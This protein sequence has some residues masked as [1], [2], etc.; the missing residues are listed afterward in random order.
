MPATTRKTALILSGGGARGA[1]QVGVLKAVGEILQ[2]KKMDN[3]F[4]I[5]SGVSAG[6]INTVSLACSKDDF[7]TSINKMIYLWSRIKPSQVFNVQLLSVGKLTQIF[8]SQNSFNAILST[9]P[10]KETLNKY[11]DFKQIDKNI[12][13][14]K[15]ET[16]IL[17]ANN[18]NTNCAVSFYDTNAKLNKNQTHWPDSRRRPQETDLRVEHVLAS[19][20]IPLLFPP[21]E[22]DGFK[23]GDGCVRNNTPCSPSLRMGAEKLFVVGVRTQKVIEKSKAQTKLKAAED[24]TLNDDHNVTM[25]K[26]INTLLNAIMLDSVEQDVHRILKIN[27]LVKKAEL[28]NEDLPTGL[29]EIPALCISPSQGLGELAREYA[30]KLPRLLRT[31]LNMFGSLDDANEILSYLMFDGDYCTKLIEIGYQ[32]ALDCKKDIINFFEA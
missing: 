11:I 21:V 31:T 9:D 5:L 7:N 13:L 16:V 12:K 10:L 19:A 1:Y 6:A 17:T 27:E 3:P 14:K 28:K 8:R 4:D 26:I 23:Y 18:Y 25:L 32:D 24:S 2:S 15:F 22:I 20:A 30:H 29:R